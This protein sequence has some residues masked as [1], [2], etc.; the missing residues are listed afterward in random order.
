MVNSD[1]RGRSTRQQ[2]RRQLYGLMLLATAVTARAADNSE[3]TLLGDFPLDTPIIQNPDIKRLST[4]A[5]LARLMDMRATNQ[6][7]ISSGPEFTTFSFTRENIYTR[8]GDALANAHYRGDDIDILRKGLGFDVALPEQ[9]T[10][11]LNLYGGRDGISRGKH[12]LFNPADVAL[13]STEG[14]RWSLGGTLEITRADQQSRRQLMFVPQLLLNV[15]Q[16]SS[17]PGHMQVA[18]MYGPWHGTLSGLSE[19]AGLTPQILLK[20]SY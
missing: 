19:N 12:W 10:L 3:I 9:G 2:L 5:L 13:P 4:H 18:L 6:W 11:H 16:F 8:M 17:V 20:W 15:N 1:R 7:G 14:G